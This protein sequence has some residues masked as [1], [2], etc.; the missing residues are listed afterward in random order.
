MIKEKI[1]KPQVLIGIFPAF[2]RGDD[3]IVNNTTT[4]HFLRQ[5][6]EKIGDDGVY[7]SLAD[8]IAPEAP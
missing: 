6:K 2:S 5:Q 3:V 7:F 4:F 8:F 1:F